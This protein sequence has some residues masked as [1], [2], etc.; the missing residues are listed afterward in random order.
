MRSSLSSSSSSSFEKV[1]FKKNYPPAEF[2]VM[3]ELGI[4]VL[5]N[6]KGDDWGWRVV[7][8]LNRELYFSF[9]I[10]NISNVNDSSRNMQ[11]TCD[12][13]HCSTRGKFSFSLSSIFFLADIFNIN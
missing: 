9:A 11:R 3:H 13:F 6:E 7:C 8:R 1:E 4:N 12:I 5:Q 2:F 10:D